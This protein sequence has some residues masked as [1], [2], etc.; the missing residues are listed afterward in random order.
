MRIEVYAQ[1]V[2]RYS[3]FDCMESYVYS[4]TLHTPR[5]VR[6]HVC[7]YRVTEGILYSTAWCLMF[8]LTP[9]THRVSCAI[10]SDM[11]LS[12]YLY[13][14]AC[15]YTCV[16]IY[17][18]ICIY[19]YVYVRIYTHLH[20]SRIVNQL[21]IALWC[22]CV[23]F[24]KVVCVQGFRTFHSFYCVLSSVN[25]LWVFHRFLFILLR[26]LFIYT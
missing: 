3:V 13:I 9:Y 2:R 5:I 17:I 20:T 11:N 21:S 26:S 16:H 18:C 6:I 10:M 23:G 24:P 15:L 19:T 4:H 8:I 14:Y 12:I 25:Y 1:S 22:V 7:V